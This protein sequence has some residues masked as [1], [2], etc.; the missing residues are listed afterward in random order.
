MFPSGFQIPGR[1]IAF[2]R[3]D[4]SG[5]HT[6]RCAL[7]AMMGG[8]TGQGACP[9]GQPISRTGRASG[10]VSCITT[11]QLWEPSKLCDLSE[12]HCPYLFT[13]VRVRSPQGLECQSKGRFQCLGTVLVHGGYCNSPVSPDALSHTKPRLDHFELWT[14]MRHRAVL[15]ISIET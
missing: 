3:S 10:F 2:K 14:H 5:A 1:M 9:R 4:P 15:V 13:E 6:F 7:W 11:Y 12:P 8:V